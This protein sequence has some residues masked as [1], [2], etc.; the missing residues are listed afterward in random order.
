MNPEAV[1]VNQARSVISLVNAP[2]NFEA[3]SLPC[4]LSP[5]P[6][7]PSLCCSTLRCSI[8]QF[9]VKRRISVRHRSGTHLAFYVY[10]RRGHKRNLSFVLQECGGE[11]GAQNWT[12]GAP[13]AA[14][15]QNEQSS[16]CLN[17]DSCET[18]II[19]DGCKTTGGTCAGPNSYANEQWQL[20]T[21]GALESMLPGHLCAT[22]GANNAVTLTPCVSPVPSAQSWEYIPA[23]GELQTAGGLCLTVPPPPAPPSNTTTLLVGRALHDGSWAVVGL[24]NLA[25]DATFSCGPPCF[26][27]LGVPAGANLTVS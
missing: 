10:Y 7:H 6:S 14:F 3:L 24:N 26:A 9:S 12:F 2:R 11:P 19:Y 15:L 25:F 27:A 22:V 5:G 8:R 21:G 16:L 13:A 20:S 23:S 1:A 4:A 17:V 18:L